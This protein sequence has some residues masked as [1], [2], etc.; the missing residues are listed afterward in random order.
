M[1]FAELNG[2]SLHYHY[3]AGEGTGIVF[4]NSL[5]T[6]FRL[7]N[8]VVERLP[9]DIPLLRLDKRGHGLSQTAPATM[10]TY[11]GDAIAL[12]ERHGMGPSLICGVSIGGMIAQTL[13]LKRPDLAAG[14]I[15][16]NTAARI[17][18]EE[19]WA[20]RIAAVE[21]ASLGEMAEGVLARWFAPAFRAAHPA[22]FEGYRAMLSRTPKEGYLTACRALRETDLRTRVSGIAV[23]TLCLS[24]N[25]DQSTPPEVVEALAA[26]IPGAEHALIEGVGYLPMAEAP[27]VVAG[28]VRDMLARIP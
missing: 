12:M 14:L 16:S 18:S 28:H 15:L 23:P 3:R 17:G 25:H 11:A 21:A 8:G 13:A 6:D 4:L 9:G 5:G 22:P 1:M 26:A 20:E 10:E 27:E 2:A 19:M 7:W 24:G